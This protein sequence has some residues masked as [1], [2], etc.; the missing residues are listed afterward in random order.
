MMAS[1]GLGISLLRDDQ[2]AADD[3][4]IFQGTTLSGNPQRD[5]SGRCCPY[6]ANR[7]VWFFPPDG[8]GR[9]H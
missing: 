8:S 4:G 7:Q 3:L 9:I 5:Q 2:C 1:L 6:L